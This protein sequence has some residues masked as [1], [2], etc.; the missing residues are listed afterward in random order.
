METAEESAA[1]R[2]PHR[3]PFQFRLRFTIEQKSKCHPV[4]TGD[5]S[6]QQIHLLRGHFGE[7]VQPQSAEAEFRFAG[8]VPDGGGGEFQASIRILQVV[9]FE[10]IEIGTEEHG[11]IAKL[12]LQLRNLGV[13]VRHRIQKVWR[14]LMLLELVEEL[15]QLFCEA[16]Q[17][18]AGPE[19]FQVGVM[20]SQQG[21]QHHH[22]S[23]LAQQPGRSGQ[24]LTK[25][26]L[27]QPLEGKN[28]QAGVAGQFRITQDLPLQLER[29]LPGRQKNQ[30]QPRRLRRQ[31]RT[32]LRQAAKS[33]SAARRAKQE[34]YVHSVNLPNIPV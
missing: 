28:L 19:E 10:P 22:P 23:L 2:G 1:D 32:N 14:D 13:F 12:V 29:R 31:S 8:R 30:R 4:A 17:T 33:F 18:R 16:G 3:I 26:K 9:F 20:A 11:Q 7:A 15:A 27:G 34:V 6:R 25:D 24:K 21:P 5:Q